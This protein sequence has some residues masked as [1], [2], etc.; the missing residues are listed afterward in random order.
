MLQLTYFERLV[1]SL[2]I[3]LKINKIKSF[4]N[5]QYI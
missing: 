2:R 5:Y 4:Q 1:I 3:T